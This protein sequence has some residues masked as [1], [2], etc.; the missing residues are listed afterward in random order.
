M[1][2]DERARPR[3]PRGDEHHIRE[4]AQCDHGCH[5]LPA[6]PLP[7]HEGVLRAYR[8]DQREAQAEAGERGGE[9]NTDARNLAD[10]APLMLLL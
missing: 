6:D 8:D 5:V 1:P 4:R 3:Y 10:P 7:Q 9:H 2:T